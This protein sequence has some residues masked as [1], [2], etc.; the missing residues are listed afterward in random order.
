MAYIQISSGLPGISG[1]M[2]S[3]PD[4]AEPL[5]ALAQT[6]LRGKS[7]L[8][9]GERELI[10]WYVSTLN[11]CSFCASSHGAIA[12][13]LLGV[14]PDIYWR[15]KIDHAGAKKSRLGALMH[16][17]KHVQ[18]GGQKVSPDDIQLARSVGATEDEIHE[19]VLIAAAFCMYNRYVDGLRTEV[20]D[21]EDYLQSAKVLVDVGYMR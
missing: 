3:R 20:G 16:I 4:L 10:A 8:S 7:T 11:E 15:E 1:L 19:T 14:E 17:A 6:L 5:R 18:Q 2:A 12:S 9:P 13:L 21:A